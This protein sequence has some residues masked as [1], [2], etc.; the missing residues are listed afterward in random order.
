MN[1]K[2]IYTFLIALLVPIS[3]SSQN[4]NRMKG[5]KRNQKLIRIATEAV[6]TYMP[7]YY[8]EYGKPII[9]KYII[10]KTETEHP[11]FGV[12]KGRVL[13]TIEFPYDKSK[14]YFRNGFAAVVRIWGD[15]GEVY[16]VMSGNHYGGRRFREHEAKT[17]KN[18]L[19]PYIKA[20]K[21]KSNVEFI[22]PEEYERRKLE[23]QKQ[24]QQK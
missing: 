5:E 18:V 3:V 12:R 20:E 6:K 22:S 19:F 21:P 24:K 23:R 2:L 13:Y 14:E 1:T 17:I 11:E 4:L 7:E 10:E 16:M 9:E 15:N 8:R